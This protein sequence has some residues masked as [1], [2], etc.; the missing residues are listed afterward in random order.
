MILMRKCISLQ[1]S[2]T[3]RLIIFLTFTSGRSHK[4]L[5]FYN[6]LTA[7]NDIVYNFIFPFSAATDQERGG[8]GGVKRLHLHRGLQ[9]AAREA[10]H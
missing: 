8:S 4:I 9:A 7:V 2:D 5:A 6:I 10:G 3:V 1:F